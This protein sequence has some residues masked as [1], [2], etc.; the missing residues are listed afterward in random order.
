MENKLKHL[1][2]IQN[3]ISRLA[4]NSFY[5]KGWTITLVVALL[6]LNFGGNVPKY[7]YL[8]YIIIIFFW[9]LNGYFLHQERLFRDLYDV[10]RQKP[11][12]EVDFSMDASEYDHGH[13][14][15]V[16]STFSKTLIMF[17]GGLILGVLII[18]HLI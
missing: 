2:F 14:S 17:Y 7:I 18:L 13:S 4:N 16:C 9:I 12:E 3:V 1:D 15:W 8:P 6:G 11:V 5:I 10:V